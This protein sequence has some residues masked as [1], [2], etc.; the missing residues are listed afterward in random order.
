MH[1]PLLFNPMV[2]DLG[3]NA[4]FDMDYSLGALLP[5]NNRYNIHQVKFNKI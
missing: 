2:S 1:P 4:P 5:N 3:A